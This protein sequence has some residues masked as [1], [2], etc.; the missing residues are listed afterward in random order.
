[1]S[2]H[3]DKQALIDAMLKKMRQQLEEKLPHDNA[4]LDQIEDAVEEIGTALQREL[5]QRIADQR[6]KKPRDN[7]LACPCGG[8]ALYKACQRRRVLTRQGWLSW[9]RPWYYC[10]GCKQGFAPLDQAL[11]LDAS[12]TTRTLRQWS[13]HLAAHLSFAQ[14]VTTLKIC[15]ERH[16]AQDLH[17]ASPRSRP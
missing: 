13:A 16:H 1:M 3:L 9:Q 8:V 11:G 14:S 4:T 5:Q 17:R 6:A 15:T 2:S 10:S 7:R 12:D